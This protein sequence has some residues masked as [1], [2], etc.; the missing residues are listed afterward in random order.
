MFFTPIRP[1]IAE[2]KKIKG[3]AENALI[4]AGFDIGEELIQGEG[5]FR[6]LQ[7]EELLVPRGLPNPERLVE[8]PIQIRDL[9]NK[10]FRKAV[11]IN[12]TDRT[13]YVKPGPKGPTTFI[14]KF[15]ALAA[16]KARA[17][18]VICL[19]GSIQHGKPYEFI[20]LRVVVFGP[21]GQPDGWTIATV[22]IRGSS[23]LNDDGWETV[24]DIL[25]KTREDV[26]RYSGFNPQNGEGLERVLALI[27]DNEVGDGK[28]AEDDE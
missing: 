3:K 23:I 14:Y 10:D 8:K 18:P 27:N 19:N 12:K 4:V 21:Y 7:E 15:D 17:E 9:T 16:E 22:N 1:T 6:E 13:V 24:R 28:S 11:I 5:A 26:L 25:E 2:L 20:G